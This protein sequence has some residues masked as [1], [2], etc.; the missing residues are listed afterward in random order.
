PSL[1]FSLSAG[2]FADRRGNRRLIMIVSDIASAA[3][4]LSIPIAYALGELTIAQL[5]VVA[6]IVGT[7]E[8]FFTVCSATMFISVTDRDKYVEGQ[9]LL[10]GSRATSDV[11]G[12]SGAGLL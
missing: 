8:V 7:F 2:A 12:Q 3:L 9:S 1:L 5:Y 11:L 10:N 4:M 6:F